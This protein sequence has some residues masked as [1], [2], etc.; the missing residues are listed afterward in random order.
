MLYFKALTEGLSALPPADPAVRARIDA[1]AAGEGWPAMHSELARVDPTTARRL[2]PNDAQRIQRALEVFAITGS[3]LSALQG[4]R[5]SGGAL[6]PLLRIALVPTDR[7]ALHAAIAQRFDSML[8]AG[9]VDELRGLRGRLPLT[10]DLPSMRCV[11][12]RQAWEFLDRRIDAA[13]LRDMGIAATRQLA[14][15][16]LTWLR[17]MSGTVFDPATPG[18]VD[19]VAALL[20][21]VP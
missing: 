19:A 5:E 11:G 3:P 12:Y 17:A 21:V 13:A 4:A 2:E 14:K 10:P 7:A 6:D 16:Q 9:L 18:L 20:S 15:R 8:A 1:R